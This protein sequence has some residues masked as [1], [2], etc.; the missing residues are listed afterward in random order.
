MGGSDWIRWVVHRMSYL[1][2]C[3]TKTYPQGALDEALAWIEEGA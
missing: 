2:K 3:E 1:T